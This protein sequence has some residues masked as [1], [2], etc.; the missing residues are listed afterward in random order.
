M[1]IFMK[2]EDGS[3]RRDDERHVNVLVDTSGVPDLLARHGVRA[4]LGYAF[5][6]ERLPEGLYTLIGHR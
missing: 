6:N 1:A 4:T 3:W 5:G 2:N